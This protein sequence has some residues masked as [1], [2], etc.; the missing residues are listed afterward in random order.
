M[1]SRHTMENLYGKSLLWTNFDIQDFDFMKRL[2]FVRTAMQGL[3]LDTKFL[4]LFSIEFYQE[5]LKVAK[6]DFSLDPKITW[7]EKRLTDTNATIDSESN[8][9]TIGLVADLS[10]V[11]LNT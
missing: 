5:V 7:T 10:Q 2:V 8:F 4:Y 3:S 1:Q 6:V 9:H 11:F